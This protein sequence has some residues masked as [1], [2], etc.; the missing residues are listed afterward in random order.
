MFLWPYTKISVLLLKFWVNCFLTIPLSLLFT[1]HKRNLLDMQWVSFENGTC[2]N[3]NC[4]LFT[5]RN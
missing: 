3:S 2:F 4:F 1:G 5:V